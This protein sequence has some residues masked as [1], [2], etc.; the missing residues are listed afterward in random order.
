ME[1]MMKWRADKPVLLQETD[2]RYAK[3]LKQLQEEGICDSELWSLDTTI[4]KFILPRLKAFYEVSVN[5]VKDDEFHAD[6]LRIIECFEVYE[7]GVM[8]D[9]ISEMME[10]GLDLLRKVF[11]GLWW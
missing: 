3:E 1:W 9:N 7:A 2:D 4:I 8:Q 5:T 10:E 6:I 11:R